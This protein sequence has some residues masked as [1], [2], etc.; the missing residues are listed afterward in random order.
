MNNGIEHEYSSE[1]A[2][3]AQAFGACGVTQEQAAF[4]FGIS[5]DTYAKYY[6]EAHR[7]GKIFASHKV[8]GSLFRNATIKDNVIAQIFWLK[9]QAGWREQAQEIAESQS[10]VL[11]VEDDGSI[12]RLDAPEEVEADA[13]ASGSK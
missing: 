11:L 8:A 12:A 9:T 4:C 7:K 13:I 6:G 2:A 3:Q 10:E 5:Q 1:L